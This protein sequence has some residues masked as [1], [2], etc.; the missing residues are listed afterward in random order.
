MATIQD[1]LLAWY[2]TNA[3]DL[4]WRRTRDPYRVLVSEIMLQQTQVD[5]VLPYYDVFIQRFPS[6]QA[7]AAAPVGEVIKAWGGL[8]YNRR[9]V[10]LHRA[11]SHIVRELGGVFPRDVPSLLALPGIGPYTA[12]AVACFAF[13]QDVAFVD[14]NMRRVVHR[15]FV[16]V[17][18]P[19]PAVSESP[20]LRIAATA[21]PAGR[22]WSWNQALIEFGALQCTARRPACVVCPLQA[23]CRAYPAIQSAIAERPRTTGSESATPYNGSRRYFRGRVIAA[24]RDLPEVD[25]S[26]GIDLHDLG[27]RI[28]DGF[29]EQDVPWLLDIVQELSREGL[30]IAAEDTPPY[31]AENAA[32]AQ[33]RPRVRLP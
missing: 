8:G 12:G 33:Q 18:V 25:T 28:R 29:S 17:D 9:A 32:P 4:P 24:L 10:N 31:D 2:A 22:G 16:G 6:I 1:T 19:R 27:Q 30:A 15:L 7:L 13:E 14:T 21:V 11:A 20:L 5:R 26:R 3:R 23:E